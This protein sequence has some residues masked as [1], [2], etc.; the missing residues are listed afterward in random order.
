MKFLY[1]DIL[2]FFHNKPSKAMLSEK[3]FQLGH[4]HEIIDDIFDIDLTPNRGDCL[5][6]RGLSRDLNVFFENNEFPDIYE[7]NIGELN[8]NFENLS[9]QDCPKIT[10]LEISIDKDISEYKPYLNNFFLTLGNNKTNFFTDVSNYLSYELGQPTHCYD[11]KLMNGKLSFKNI[12]CNESF[13]TLLNSNIQLKDKNCVF[14]LDDKIINLAGIMGGSSTSCSSS[15][16][17]ALIECAYFNPEAIIG[18]SVKYN[19]NSEAAYKFERG[20]DIQG[21]NRTLKRFIKIVQ[22]HASI[23]SLRIKTFTEKKMQ[24]K[25][26]PIDVN[27]INGILGTDIQDNQYKNYLTKLGFKVGDK[28]EV[29]TYRHDITSQN[30]LSEE[31][32][33][34]LGYNNIINQPIVLSS[35]TNKNETKLNKISNFLVKNGFTEVI[36][37]PF[38]S[39][40]E[41]ESITIDNPLDVNK[42]FLRTSLKESLL[43]NLLYNERR[44]KDSIKLFEISNVYYKKDNLI[45]QKIRLGVIASGRRG[46]DYINFTKKLDKNYLEDLLNEEIDP[47]VFEFEEID[48]NDIKTKR[49]EKIFYTEV[50][51][52]DVPDIFYEN[53]S[54]PKKPIKFPRF[55]KVSEFPSSN[56]DF[57]FSVSNM[58]QYNKVIELIDNFSHEYLKESFIFDFYRN[59]DGKEIK[60]GVRLVFQSSEKTLCDNEINNASKKILQPIIDLD[61]VNIP[62]LDA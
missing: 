56:R 22:D 2:K 28:I 45:N 31:V 34:V 24:Q 20:V 44:Q 19:L 52:N 5:S 23:K 11:Q 57:S 18:K 26:I 14:T 53:I 15:T 13:T 17:T 42:K 62:G 38:S 59:I 43:D 37:F 6:L 55:K 12:P 61:G 40:K 60:I 21:Q 58:N 35:F 3:L 54:F 1:Q 7:D 8:L 16:R 36:N 46:H 48:R 25:Y 33:R 29:P 4:E 10:F 50:L 41:Q 9:I 32:A 39:K 51:L 27:K 47:R 30:D 49:N